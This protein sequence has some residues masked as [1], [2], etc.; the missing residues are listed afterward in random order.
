MPTAEVKVLARNK[1]LPFVK[2]QPRCIPPSGKT[3]VSGKPPLEKSPS[4]K[5][6]FGQTDFEEAPSG[7]PQSPGCAKI[8]E[9]GSPRV[10]MVQDKQKCSSLW[11]TY[12]FVLLGRHRLRFH[13]HSWSSES[14][15]GSSIT[16]VYAVTVASDAN[17]LEGI[18]FFSDSI[19]PFATMCRMVR[20][21]PRRGSLKIKSVMALKFWNNLVSRIVS[22]PPPGCQ[23]PIG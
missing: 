11:R 16:S 23:V 21:K 22:T 17:S 12:F 6:A 9:K 4:M 14:M 15:D 18:S 2:K 10:S 7:K 13:L 5:N 1:H 20:D 8:D 3:I 19:T